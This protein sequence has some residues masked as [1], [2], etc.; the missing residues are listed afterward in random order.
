MN[1]FSQLFASFSYAA[2]NISASNAAVSGF[3]RLSA[4]K[5]NSTASGVLAG[6]LRPGTLGGSAARLNSAGRA[7]IHSHK[8]TRVPASISFE[9]PRS[10]RESVSV[11]SPVVKSL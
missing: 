5:Y 3:N 11:S 1:S 8:A 10:M 9:P 2:L 4:R 6:A 7:P